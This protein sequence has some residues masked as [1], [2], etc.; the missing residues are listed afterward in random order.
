[1]IKKGPHHL[2]KVEMWFPGSKTGPSPTQL[3]LEILFIYMKTTGL[4]VHKTN[5]K[6]LGK[7]PCTL[8]HPQKSKEQVHCSITRMIGLPL[9]KVQQ[10]TRPSSLP[11]WHRLYGGSRGVWSHDSWNTP[12]SPPS[13]RWEPPPQSATPVVSPLTSTQYRKDMSTRTA[14]QHP[15]AFR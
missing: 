11:P 1:M 10:S 7:L 15:R 14:L 9:S 5:V 4:Q 8:C 3:R 13:W 12:S 6:W 2:Q